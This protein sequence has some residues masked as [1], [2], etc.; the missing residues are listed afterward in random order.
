MTLALL[1]VPTKLVLL[2]IIV[3]IAQLVQSGRPV[4]YQDYTIQILVKLFHQQVEYLGRGAVSWSLL[5]LR[6]WRFQDYFQL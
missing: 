2:I 6:F 4:Q 3:C 5:L 1:L